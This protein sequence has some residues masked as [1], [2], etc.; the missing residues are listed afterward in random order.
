MS[1]TAL[2]VLAVCAG[3]IIWGFS[4]LFIQTALN[5]AE[6]NVML[7]VRFVIAF[8]LINIPL[9]T[10]KQ[11]IS[12]KGKPVKTLILFSLLE[13]VYFFIESYAVLYTN[14]TYTGVGLAVSPI[15]SIALAAVLLKE[16]PSHRQLLFCTLPITGVII[17]TVSGSSLGIVSPVGMLFLAGLCLASA[18]KKTLNRVSSMDFTTYERTY[19]IMLSNAVTFPVAALIS[20]KG[21]LS[22]FV[23]PLTHPQFIL[24]ILVLCIF[25]SVAA[26]MLVNYAAGKMSVARFSSFGTITTVCSAFAG[27]IFLGEPCTPPIFIGAALIIIGII[28]FVMTFTLSKL[29]G[30]LERRLKAGA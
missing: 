11:T 30:F 21:Q 3:Y 17:M 20:T 8:L 14:T 15:F 24:S 29:L 19:F 12:L 5:Y 16:F 1:R 13:P 4:F 25:C 9:L 18:T 6:P 2:P 27:V 23:E 7:A 10:K 28:Y 26:N 22:S